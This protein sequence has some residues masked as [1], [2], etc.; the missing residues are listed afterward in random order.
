LPTTQGTLSSN[1]KRNKEKK[2]SWSR[3]KKAQEPLIARVNVVLHAAAGGLALQ[4]AHHWERAEVIMA[5]Q[6]AHSM[7]C[8]AACGPDRCALRDDWGNPIEF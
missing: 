4:M 1:K 5:R 6:R 2:N 7:C 3:G 8:R